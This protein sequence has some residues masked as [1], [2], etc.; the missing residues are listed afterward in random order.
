MASITAKQVNQQTYTFLAELQSS[1]EEIPT[2]RLDQHRL[3]EL[4]VHVHPLDLT[5]T[6]A[7]NTQP[8]YFTPY[9]SPA[10]AE[11]KKREQ[12]VEYPVFDGDWHWTLEQ[13]AIEID[14]M[15]TQISLNPMTEVASDLT[16]WEPRRYNTRRVAAG[17]FALR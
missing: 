11:L 14:H 16:A 9:P 4:H 1:L 3:Q 2:V 6:E 8:R 15:F 12:E 7:S 10:G 5:S 17:G 13:R